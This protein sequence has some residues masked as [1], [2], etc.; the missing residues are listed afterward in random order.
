MQELG[1][2]QRWPGAGGWPVAGPLRQGVHEVGEQQKRR[3]GHAVVVTMA[4]SAW[5]LG[6]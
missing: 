2:D 1:A 4:G 6:S 3:G 5:A